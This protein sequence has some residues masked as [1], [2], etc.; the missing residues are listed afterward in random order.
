MSDMPVSEVAFLEDGED[1]AEAMASFEERCGLS[2]W[3]DF[4]KQPVIG[5][6]HDRAGD[7]ARILAASG[8]DVMF[9]TAVS[10][11]GYGRVT[12]LAVPSEDGSKFHV[13]LGEGYAPMGSTVKR[14]KMEKCLFGP[15]SVTAFTSGFYAG[16]AADPDD[17][18]WSMVMRRGGRAICIGGDCGYPVGYRKMVPRMGD[19]MLCLADM[20]PVPIWVRR[21][22]ERACFATGAEQELC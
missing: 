9:W 11:A 5:E 14:E 3:R 2:S 17:R 15:L 10:R 19:V 1:P 16:G 20:V 22:F 8:T 7:L 6:W 12:F 4:L 18:V 13:V 21:R